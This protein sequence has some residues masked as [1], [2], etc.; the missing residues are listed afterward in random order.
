M[1]SSFYGNNLLK[2]IDENLI[3]YI[4]KHYR[5]IFRPHPENFKDQKI[6]KKLKT[7]KLNLENQFLK[8]AMILK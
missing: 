5:I 6:V 2:L 3:K 1:A 8:L 4:L 7:L